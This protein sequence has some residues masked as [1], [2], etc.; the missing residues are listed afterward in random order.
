MSNSFF[1]IDQVGNFVLDKNNKALRV[2]FPPEEIVVNQR[3]QFPDAAWRTDTEFGTAL[4]EIG[5]DI[6]EVEVDCT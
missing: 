6:K 4:F 2:S 3:R 1:N 5:D